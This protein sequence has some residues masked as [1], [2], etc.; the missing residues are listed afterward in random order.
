[1]SCETT[2]F[3]DLTSKL[4]NEKDTARNRGLRDWVSTP[5]ME[6]IVRAK[7]VS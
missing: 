3:L 4:L 5:L 7:V 6:H 2:S 1:M